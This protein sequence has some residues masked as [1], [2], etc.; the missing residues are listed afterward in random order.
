MH[1]VNQTDFCAYLVGGDQI[2]LNL[3]MIKFEGRLVQLILD[4]NTP[5]EF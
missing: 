2:L 1:V 5:T 4:D 3:L